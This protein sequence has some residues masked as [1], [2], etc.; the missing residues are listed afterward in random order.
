MFDMLESI[1]DVIVTFIGYIID[2]FAQALNL[3]K[4]IFEGGTF[5]VTAFSYLPVEYRAALYYMVA[6]TIIV[7]ILHFGE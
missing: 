4:L 3:F 7:T 1:L 5:F 6:L 2:F